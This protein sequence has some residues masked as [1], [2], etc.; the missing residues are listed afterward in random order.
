MIGCGAG[1]DLAHPQMDA[2]KP[3]RWWTVKICG[4]GPNPR[5]GWRWRACARRHE[6]AVWAASCGRR[7]PAEGRDGACVRVDSLEAEGTV[8]HRRLTR[9]RA[10]ISV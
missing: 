10:L 4:G 1:E 5:T 3:L 2:G 7:E 9:G 8:A 6:G